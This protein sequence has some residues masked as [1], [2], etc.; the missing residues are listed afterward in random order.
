MPTDLNET[1]GA[2]LLGV[3]VTAV[4]FGITTMQTYLY[5]SRFPKDPWLIRWTVWSLLALDTIHVMLSWHMVYYYLIINYDNRPALGDSVWSFNITVVLTAFITVIVHCFYARRVYILSRG[6]W[7]VVLLIL[8]LSVVRVVC[9]AVVTVRLF[10]IKDLDILPK[11]IS[12]QVGTGLGAGTLADILITASLVVLLK[13]HQSGFNLL[14]HTSLTM[15]PPPPGILFDR[16]DNFLDKIIYWTVNNGAIT[17]IVGLVVIVTFS[18]M[19]EN[20]VFLAVH[21]LLSKLYANSLLATLNFRA[22]HRGR[23]FETTDR[24]NSVTIPMSSMAGERR[25]KGSLSMGFRNPKHTLDGSSQ[26]MSTQTR[27]VPVVHI[28]KTTTTDDGKYPLPVA[29]YH[30]GARPVRGTTDKDAPFPHADYD[31]DSSEVH[32]PTPTPSAA[33]SDLKSIEHTV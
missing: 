25:A 11:K 29:D 27:S 16:L 4:G 21:L 26:T 23:G 28:V 7:F 10:Q 20:M 22:A 18:V 17:S 1:V 8:T 15:R 9:G 2:L 6:L 5:M 31:F 24:D 33:P 32:T 12:A 30:D 14:R 3:L 19:P 13:R